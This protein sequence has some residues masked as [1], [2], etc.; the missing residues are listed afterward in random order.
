MKQQSFAS[1]SY[2]AKKRKTRKELFLE[3]MESCVPWVVFEAIIEPYYSKS[4]RR[5]G[6]PIGLTTMLRIYLMQQW[7]QLSDPMM[8]DAL[9]EIESMRIFAKLELCEDR[10]PVE[11]TILKFRHLLER[12]QLTGKFFSA[13]SK[14]LQLHGLALSKG[15]MVD[16]TLISASSSTKNAEGTRDSEMHQTRKGNQW[17][18]GMKIHVS[19]DV[20]SGTAHTVTVT[21]ANKADIGE[22][23]ALLRKEDEVI[24]GDEGYT[25]D[26]YKRGAR[27]LGLHWQVNDKRKT[28]KGNLS[29]SQRKR[30]RQQSKIR[31]RVEHLFRI[32]KCQFGYRKVRYRGLEKN[33][34]QV[35]SLMAMANLYL[36]HNA[37]TA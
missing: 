7:F 21:S 20:N 30:N 25:S 31:V 6:L 14:R 18:F 3:K 11:T 5:E 27:C 33:R 17:Y 8:E 22:L 37:L 24:F 12:N 1:L 29:S 2:A 4:G 34:V 35:M 36:Q 15:T 26:T 19:A 16:A 13:V 10:L 9:Y 32:L 23:P 28:R